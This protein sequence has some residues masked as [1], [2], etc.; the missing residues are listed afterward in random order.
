MVGEGTITKNL[1]A[2]QF[3]GYD[4]MH[5]NNLDLE[6]T[7]DHAPMLKALDSARRWR[8]YHGSAGGSGAPSAGDILNHAASVTAAGHMQNQTAGAMS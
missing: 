2:R 5:L 6:S 7:A 1:S 3:N 4:P 8:G